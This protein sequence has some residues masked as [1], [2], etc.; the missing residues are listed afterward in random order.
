MEGALKK[1]D[2]LIESGNKFTFD[3]FST[4]TE[5]GYVESYTSAWLSWKVRVSGAISALFKSDSAQFKMISAAD[6]INLPGYG[7]DNFSLAMSHYMGALEAARDLL[8]DDTFGEL[9][10]SSSKAPLN[11]SNRVFI[12]HGHD[13]KSKTDLEILLSE[14]GLEP[15]VLHRQADG[16]RTII[17]KFEDYADVGYAF[18]LLTPDE[19]T[20]LASEESKEDSARLKE[21]RARPNVIFEFGYF[22]GRLGRTRTCCLYKSPVTLPSD[23]SGVIY[24]RFDKDIEEIAYS[25]SK[26]LKNAGYKLN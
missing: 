26:E 11:Y 24:K 13:D 9:N 21:H 23:V 20:Y 8:G 5:R 4:K 19:V 17:E 16:G 15:M 18:I 10:N 3:N 22:V 25:I 6:R 14:M 12:V 2:D 7:Q 1:I